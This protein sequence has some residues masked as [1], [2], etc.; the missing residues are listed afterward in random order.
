MEISFTLAHLIEVSEE[1]DVA[2]TTD[3][4]ICGIAS[5]QDAQSGDLSFLGNNKYRKQVA[6]SQASVLLLPRDYE[7]IPK[8]NQV[9]V[10]TDDPSRILSKIALE[11]EAR[12]W[13]RPGGETHPTAIVD[14]SATIAPSAYI[15][16]GCVIGEGVTIGEWVYL[17]ANVFV[18]R[19][20]KIETGCR[21][22]ANVVVQDYCELGQEVVLQSGSV[23]GSDGYGY[24]TQN[25]I[26]SRIPQIGNVVLEDYVEVGANS[27]IDR[28][29]FHETRVK[30]G[31][32]IDN[33][34]QIAHNVSIGEHCFIVAQ[35]GIG[36]S[37]KIGNYVTLAGQSGIAGHLEI[38]DGAIVAGQAGL[39]RDMEAGEKVRGTPALPFYEFQRIATLSKRL[40]EV[41]K[42]LKNLEDHLNPT[43]P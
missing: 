20:V 37:T 29:R 14:E 6:G 38:G 41:F 25:G 19:K 2:G 43:N 33:L 30:T 31:T 18:G 4:H 39:T 23:I 3:Q 32:K 17:Q 5:L 24:T 35:T 15:G 28:A 26:H 42:R 7:G 27:T 11:L 21:L 36:G 34:V 1:P 16:P 9:Y 22:F 13:A 40:P 10:R 8:E 12:F